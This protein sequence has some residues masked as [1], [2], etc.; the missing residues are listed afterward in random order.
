VAQIR[1]SCYKR[2][3]QAGTGAFLLFVVQGLCAPATAQAGCNH[4]VVSR[5]D[6]TQLQPL[7]DSFLDDVA[8]RP[9]PLPKSPRPCSGAWC[10]GQPVVPP[11][12]AGVHD[13]RIESWAWNARGSIVL[14]PSCSL[15]P[16]SGTLT[17]PIVGATGI[18]HPPRVLS[19]V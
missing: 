2:L 18:F 4:R 10:S 7:V 3:W 13:W 6:T 16:V 19:S 8:E 11:V 15:F 9:Q 1:L 17:H 12:S 14:R 5:T